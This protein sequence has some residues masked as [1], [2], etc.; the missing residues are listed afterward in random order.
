MLLGMPAWHRHCLDPVHTVYPVS[1]PYDTPERVA[2]VETVRAFAMDEVLPVAN[3][4]DP[5]TRTSPQ[6]SSSGWAGSGCSAC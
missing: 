5:A 4:L 2:L 6:R 3:R 1:S